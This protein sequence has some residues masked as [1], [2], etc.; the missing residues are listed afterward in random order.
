MSKRC[1]GKCRA[2]R[3]SSWCVIRGLEYLSTNITYMHHRH[4]FQSL[5]S[6][7]SRDSARA[8]ASQW[9]LVL[10]SA[11]RFFHLA[12]CRADHMGKGPPV[13]CIRFDRPDVWRT[14]QPILLSD[15]VQPQTAHMIRRLGLICQAADTRDTA[16]IASA[17]RLTLSYGCSVVTECCEESVRVSRKCADTVGMLLKVFPGKLGLF[18]AV[19]GCLQ[20]RRHIRSFAV[21]PLEPCAAQVA[22]CFFELARIVRHRLCRP[23]PRTCGSVFIGITPIASDCSPREPITTRR[24]PMSLGMPVRRTRFCPTKLHPKAPSRLHKGNDRRPCAIEGSS[25]L[26]FCLGLAYRSP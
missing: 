18:S 3:W 16:E 6:L 23:I 2:R 13:L 15:I 22:C 14:V 19:T 11:F 25:L 17:C 10:S 7:I 8:G 9:Q 5:T 1:R 4:V 24:E 12:C 21:T 20:T 26:R